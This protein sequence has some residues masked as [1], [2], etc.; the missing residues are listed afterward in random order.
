MLM[1]YSN[2]KI[3]MNMKK[4]I[5]F[6]II[7]IIA[8]LAITSCE[9][10]FNDVIT[11]N[12]NQPTSV[13]PSL[14]FNGVI[15]DLYIAPWG[16]EEKWCQYFLINYDYYG[17]NRYD[18]GSGTQY[19]T[20]LKNVVQMEAEAKRIGLPTQNPYNALGKFFR[21][22]YFSLMSLE[23]GDI[24][25]TNALEGVNNLTPTF[26]SQKSVFQQSFNWLDSANI[27]LGALITAGDKSLQ[28]DIYYGN[29][30]TKWQKLVNTYRLRLLIHLSNRVNDNADMQIAQQFAMILGNSAKYPIMGSS[31][32]NL[33]YN[34]IYPTN[35]YPQNPGQFGYDALRENCSDTYVGLLTKF[36]DP[37]L[38]VTSEPAQAY[39]DS[40]KVPPTSF[41][42]F[43]GANSGEDLG[44][45][46]IKANSGEYSLI[47]RHRYYQTY[48]GE[49]SIQIGYPE[50]CF[51][52][53][54]AIN[55]GW[56][57]GKSA[58]DAE[59]SYKT[60]IQE[61]MNFYGIPQIGNL[62][63]YFLHPGASLG[64]YDTY[65]I[66]VDFNAYYNQVAV[67]YDG[68][69]TQ[70]LRQIL[71][72][73]YLALFRHSGLESYF[74]YRRTMA[75]PN[76]K[77]LGGVPVF[78]TGPGTGNSGRIAWRFQYPSSDKTANT[79]NYQDALTSQFGG[80]DDINGIMWILK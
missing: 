33:Q 46:Y 18:F 47:N 75:D 59:N 54:E 2:E 22:Y 10:S 45:M 21:A 70:G 3:F 17:N 11:S 30:L 12:P 34:Y 37:R 36:Q 50:M 5:K 44:A 80:N 24:P 68:N 9:K 43:V 58:A 71:Q 26:D 8:A 72:Q 28:N 39:V 42:V 29:D 35:L 57:P 69:T 53:A 6:P 15:N 66:P 1:L 60:G 73:R 52:I 55:R 25:M 48:T 27:Q 32:D 16:Q 20:T 23:M 63:V 19:Y 14:L 41:N 77:T 56:I 64:T 74:T 61:S 79:K 4:L 78:E 62:T 38:F 76:L 7:L 65:S 13:P 49:P 31:A 51:S 67:K 40:L